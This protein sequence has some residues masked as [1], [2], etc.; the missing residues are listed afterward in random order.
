MALLKDIVAPPPRTLRGLLHAAN[1]RYGVEIDWQPGNERVLVLAPHMDDEVLGCGGALALHHEAGAHITVAFLTD[2][3]RGSTALA[4]LHGAEFRAAQARLV[5]VRK[6]EAECA[7]VELGID[8]LSFLDSPDGALAEDPEAPGKLRA[9]IETCRPQVVYL[10]S[11][12]EQHPDH[13]ATSALLMTAVAGSAIEFTCHAY[14]VWTPL[15][16]N[17]LVGIDSVLAIKRRALAH[18]RSQLEEADFEHGIVGLNAYRA[19]M[20]PRPG[21]RYAE[22]FVALPLREYL[23]MYLQFSA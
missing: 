12:L 18:Y 19:M 14:E 13:R 3:S 22:A 11:H 7:R 4:D 9:I 15:Y 17:C 23:S 2:G 1:S 6:A 5:G 16:A 20:R 21:R 8:E 10:P